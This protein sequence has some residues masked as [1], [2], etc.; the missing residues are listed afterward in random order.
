M[1]KLVLAFLFVLSTGVLFSQVWFENLPQEKVQ[2]GELS[3]FEIQ[4]A[5]NDYW[6]PLDVE[7]GYYESNG[8]L[9]K[10]AGWKQFKRWEWYWENRVDPVS[11][12]FPNTSAFEQLNDYLSN[13][14]VDRSA[15]GN[16]TSMGPNTTGGGYAG[17]GRLN[18]V[19]FRPGD[20]NTIYVG[21]PSGGVWKSTDGG[22]N[23]T[24][25]GDNNAIIGVSD[26][27][28]IAGATT[29]SDIV[30]IAT[31][32]RDAGDNYS[33]GV[34]KSTDGGTTWAAT[35][36]SFQ[37]SQSRKANRLILDPGN[38]N[39]LYVA[40][41]VGVYKTTDAGANWVLQTGTN[42]IDMEM[43]PGTSSTLYG[44]TTTGGIYRT[45]NSGANWTQVLSDASGRRTELAVSANNSTVVYAVM[46]NSGNGLH[47]IYKSTNSGQSFSS[48]FSGTTT[49]LLNWDCSST[50]SGGQA[51]YDLCIAADPTNANTLFVGGVNTWK[52]TNGGSSWSIS[53]H[54]SGTCS[55]G[56]TTVHADK[57]FMAYQNGTSTLFECND[58]G[59]YKTTNA[60]SSWSHLSNG[61]EIS[62]IYKIGVAQTVNNDVV[63]GLQDNGTKALITGNWND[64]IGGDGMDCAIDP[65]N[66]N[67]QYGELYYGDIKRTTNHW[68]SSTSIKSG[69]SGSAAWVAPFIIDPS[70]TNTL[71]MGYQDVFKSTNQGSSWTKISSWSGSTLRSL[72]IAPSSANTICA[73]TT[74]TLYRTTNGGS[75]WTNITGSFGG[76]T[77]TSIAI[78]NDDPNTIW[79][80]LGQFNA[81]SVF[82]STDGGSSWTNISTGL[83]QIPTLSV[84]QNKQNVA[85]VELYV[86]TD[87]GVYMKK[88]TAD[89]IP[90]F[91]GLPNVVVSEVEIYYAANPADSRIRAA[92][93]GR[94]LWESDLS[95]S[96]TVLTA[97]FSADNVTPKIN[98]TVAFSDA[99]IGAPTS[100]NWVF[101]PATVTYVD[102]TSAASQNPKVQF[103]AVGNYTVALTVSDGTDNDVET[104]TNYIAAND[105]P[106]A[107]CASQGNNSTY[108]WISKVEIGSFVK[109]SAAANYSD[110]TSETVNLSPGTS[111]AVTLTPA[112]SGSTYTEFWKIWIDYNADGDF[113]DA[114]EE[115]FA[116]ASSSSTVSGNFTV[117]ADA[118]GTTR[119]RVTM[120]Y[121][122]SPTSCE[123]F[124]YGE[125]EDYTVTFGATPAPVAAF[126]ANATTITAGQSVIFTD[127][128]TNSPTSW[129]WSFTG[130]TPTSSSVQ[131]PTITYNT[132]GTYAVALT[133]TNAG[134][135]DLETKN[136]YIT[137]NPA[138][139]N[140]CTAQGNNFSYEW[141]SKVEVNGF[142]KSTAGSKY[143]DYT[144][145]VI[146]LSTGSNAVVLTPAFSSS[147][148][149]EFWRIWIDYNKDG[150]FTDAGEEVFAPA[151]SSAAVSGSFTPISSFSGQTR[152]RISMK[153]N[154][155][156]TSCESFSY[157][158][159]EDYTINVNRTPVM[160]GMENLISE[161]RIYPNPA[162]GFF[163]V[164]GDDLAGAE[165]YIYDLQGRMLMNQK[166]TDNHT[167]IQ[168]STIK[169]GVY[170]VRI[171]NN[172]EIISHK[173][174]VR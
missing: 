32:D 21:A 170:M 89:W 73:A 171:V 155:I 77:I 128:S 144:S 163:Y 1:R 165:L 38:N 160:P 31:G 148:Y 115:V 44:S 93:Y 162:E 7:N 138:P 147:T 43:N 168:T 53:T 51:W 62:Q 20:N 124:D 69:L 57:H 48:V 159:V 11:G 166:L 119:M 108:E 118:T 143:S 152:M 47:R 83:P 76:S 81:N 161:F 96:A 24:P 10:A 56:A 34:L 23:W 55:G 5:F 95:T 12:K 35:G 84:I 157:G 86:G 87:V 105:A 58:G 33:I 17:L 132:A 90:F 154:A 109:S 164:S 140:Y 137:V 70:N 46:G 52:S 80:S 150:D 99:S 65:S 113:T 151:S 107:Y 45:T 8:E 106:P 135:S 19:A 111:T 22:S 172:D 125:V 126:T 117:K 66:H 15:S 74:S 36:L 139:V 133:A 116:P 60:G 85:E 79:V 91:N 61:M 78:K 49:N 153:W 145:D 123:T 134:G 42:F 98:T 30:Y 40:T 3:F 173:I 27:V 41:T 67:T 97:A 101:T 103:T 54:W 94:G 92:T 136:A 158:E 174:V 25:M 121:N 102:G 142:S 127:Q 169:A 104:K 72:A 28:V 63:A 26:I 50:A 122:G 112:F 149:V 4:K 131:N 59:L 29:A 120:K 68:G 129:S 14:P 167:T 100:W 156:P 114:G 110:F 130:G 141:I 39:I 6:E 16:W 88:G 37:A 82:Q 2:N 146:S 13:N 75:S 18:S 64:V 9:V 71:Y